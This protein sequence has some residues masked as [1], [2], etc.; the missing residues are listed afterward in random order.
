MCT[1]ALTD[2]SGGVF[3]RYKECAVRGQSRQSLKP[4]ASAKASGPMCSPDGIP[5][6]QPLTD[7][8][9]LDTMAAVLPLNQAVNVPKSLTNAVAVFFSPTLALNQPA[10]RDDTNSNIMLLNTAGDVVL[11]ISV[12]PLQNVIVLN[13]RRAGAS[14]AAEVRITG[15]QEKFGTSVTQ[16]CIAVKDTATAFQ[17]FVNGNELAV[18]NKRLSGD[19]VKVQYAT[20]SG[21]QP[22]FSDPMTVFIC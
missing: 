6:T 7:P 19:V 17:V 12:R 9:T 5:L 21:Q 22:L 15:V 18:F 11:V 20:T 3:G 13:T 1:V 8:P 14:W 10:G 16:A 2:G 4:Q